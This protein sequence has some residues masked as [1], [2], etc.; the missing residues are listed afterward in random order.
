MRSKKLSQEDVRLQLATSMSQLVEQS[1]GIFSKDMS[2]E[3]FINKTFEGNKIETQVGNDL[4]KKAYE[5]LSKDV[6][7]DEIIKNYNGKEM[8]AVTL[9]AG[10][11]CSKKDAVTAV[12]GNEIANSNMGESLV[13]NKGCG[14]FSWLCDAAEW[15]WKNR[16]EILEVAAA[17]LA[18]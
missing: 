3:E 16:K 2:Y 8:G 17:I 1:R 10:F 4:M 9:D 11:N 13:A 6:K 15:I 14:W 5:F 12:F 18:L 7:S